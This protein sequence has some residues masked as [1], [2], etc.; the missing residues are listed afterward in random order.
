MK[1]FQVALATALLALGAAT[2][3]R[4]DHGNNN[5]NETRLKTRLAGGAIQG[6]TPE[7]NAEFRLDSKMRSQFKVEVEHVN[8]PA[9]TILDVAVQHGMTPT[10]VGHIT[11][12]AFGSGELELQSQDGDTVPAVVGGDMVIVSNAGTPILSG[13]F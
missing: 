4:A 11:L 5:N 3:A 8:L 2:I 13:T 6:K 9:G 1:K 12:N 10:I 7:G